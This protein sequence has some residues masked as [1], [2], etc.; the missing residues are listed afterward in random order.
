MYAAHATHEGND[1]GL[2]SRFLREVCILTIADKTST[3]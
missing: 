3:I 1:S 2:L